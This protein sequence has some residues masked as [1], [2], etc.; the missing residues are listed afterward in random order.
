MGD[1][2]IWIGNKAFREEIMKEGKRVYVVGC[3][4]WGGREQREEKM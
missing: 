3:W 4:V 2:D 1:G